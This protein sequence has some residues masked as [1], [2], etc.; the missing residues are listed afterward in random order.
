MSCAESGKSR[1]A[2]WEDGRSDGPFK[3]GGAISFVAGATA[4]HR[5]IIFSVLIL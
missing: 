5:K 3:V 4:A 1:V 2:E